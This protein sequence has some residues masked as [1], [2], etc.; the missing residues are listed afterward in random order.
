MASIPREP[1]TIPRHRPTASVVA[2]AHLSYQAVTLDWLAHAR[3]CGWHDYAAA[4]ELLREYQPTI[5]RT[6]LEPARYAAT[7][8]GGRRAA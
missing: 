4:L 7:G 5:Q 8:H 3:D 1:R 6:A 2:D